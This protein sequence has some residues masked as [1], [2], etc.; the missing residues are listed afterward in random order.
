M[1]IHSDK[2]TIADLQRTAPEG[3][4]VEIDTAGSR[5][6]DHS[7]KVGLSAAHGNDAHGIKRA[8][9]RNPGSSNRYVD[10]HDRAA[11]WVEWGDW[12]VELF[13]LD[14]NAII[15]E[16]DGA[17]DFII[18][19]QAA[20]PHRPERENAEVHADRWSAEL[21]WERAKEQGQVKI[22]RALNTNER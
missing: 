15:G 19:T 22:T 5:K 13:K 7:F 6:R 17:H 18:Q 20:A 12:I 14:E 3:I 9:A 16:Y 1:K 21:F 4:Y 2:L 8:F 11:T 10:H